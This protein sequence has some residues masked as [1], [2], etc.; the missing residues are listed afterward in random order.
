MRR[1]AAELRA[2]AQALEAQLKRLERLDWPRWLR[3]ADA[4]TR[5][6]SELRREATAREQGV[7]RSRAAEGQAELRA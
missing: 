5:Q 6:I 2:E 1:S 3:D 4:I 7:A